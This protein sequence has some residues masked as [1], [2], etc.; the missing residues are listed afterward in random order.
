MRIIKNG[1][2]FELVEIGKEVREKVLRGLE[3]ENNGLMRR[4]L[5]AAL[6]I[7]EAEKSWLDPAG[8]AIV[9]AALF[10]K[11]AT[12]AYTALSDAETATVFHE[13]EAAKMLAA[14]FDERR[15]EA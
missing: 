15:G 4:C 12:R 2:G 5:G 8:V 9:A 14:Q 13:K 10:D 11:L 3:E 1:N 6:E 7:R